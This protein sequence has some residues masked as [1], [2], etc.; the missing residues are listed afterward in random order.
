MSNVHILYL[1]N[2]NVL[3]VQQLRNDT[4]GDF[5][6]TANVSMTLHDAGGDPVNG[7]NWPLPLQYVDGSHGVYR[8]TLDRDLALTLNARYIAR[9]AVDGGSEL[10]ASWSIACVARHRS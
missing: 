10:R 1:D 3:E 8:V 4:S 2:D 7:A 9:I 6:N 5:L